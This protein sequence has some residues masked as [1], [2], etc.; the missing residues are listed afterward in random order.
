M[1][2]SPSR[3][4]GG[5][6][7]LRPAPPPSGN[8]PPGDP[9]PKNRQAPR[10]PARSR[11]NRRRLSRIQAQKMD[12]KQTRNPNPWIRIRTRALGKER[13]WRRVTCPCVHHPD[14][15]SSMTS[16]PFRT[17]RRRFTVSFSIFPPFFFL[18]FFLK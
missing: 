17:L 14:S 6:W 2:S 8:L 18:L 11:P 9:T 4:F 13:R 12:R 16:F 7:T 3:T 15:D 5:S 1:K 10:I